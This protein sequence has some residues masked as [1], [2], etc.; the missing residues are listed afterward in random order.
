MADQEIRAVADKLADIARI[1]VTDDD[2]ARIV[3]Y[4][5]PRQPHLEEA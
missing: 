4:Y 2:V 5:G 3:S 1:L